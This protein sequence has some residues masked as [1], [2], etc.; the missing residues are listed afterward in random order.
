M[1]GKNGQI[2]HRT[3][4]HEENTAHKQMCDNAKREQ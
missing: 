1:K 2:K 4:G 3:I